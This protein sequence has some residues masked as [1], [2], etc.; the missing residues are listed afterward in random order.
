MDTIQILPYLPITLSILTF[1]CAWAVIP[2]LLN[3]YNTDWLPAWLH[4]DSEAVDSTYR[5]YYPADEARRMLAASFF[6]AFVYIIVSL[7]VG[8]SE[9]IHTGVP[10]LYA[11]I[12][13]AY[14]LHRY[15]C[16]H[17]LNR[18]TP[19]YVAQR[20]S[21]ITIYRPWVVVLLWL[22]TFL[23]PVVAVFQWLP[24]LQLRLLTLPP[25]IVMLLFTGAELTSLCQEYR[26]DYSKCN[27]WQCLSCA[28]P[29][30]YYFALAVVSVA[31]TQAALWSD[32]LVPL[33]VWTVILLAFTVTEFNYRFCCTPDDNVD[34]FESW[35]T[36]KTS[37]RLTI[38]E[39]LELIQRKEWKA[40]RHK[41]R[42]CQMLIIRQKNSL[43]K[44]KVEITADLENKIKEM[45]LLKDTLLYVRTFDTLYEAR[46]NALYT[47]YS[48]SRMEKMIQKQNPEGRDLKELNVALLYKM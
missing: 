17:R 10:Y 18:F 29:H 9:Y 34:M 31:L 41:C 8:Q 7:C 4:P 43:R 37:L 3:S 26:K 38:E 20:T 19:E 45:F 48:D 22:Y 14:L 32:S 35:G 5:Y 27:L 33:I 12:P 42:H 11:L 6:V 21:R 28:I 2:Y 46:M 13:A 24:S 23:L 25:V 1:V 15:F 39:E 47:G 40:L 36:D 16:F 30:N 44:Y